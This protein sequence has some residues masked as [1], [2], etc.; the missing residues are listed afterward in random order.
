MQYEVATIL[1]IDMQT[2]NS[3]HRRNLLLSTISKENV[4][5]L[6]QP[7]ELSTNGETKIEVLTLLKTH[8]CTTIASKFVIHKMVIAHCFVWQQV[9]QKLSFGIFKILL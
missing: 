7:Y 3:Q 1:A 9:D 4:V 5:I 8:I 6:V 2:C